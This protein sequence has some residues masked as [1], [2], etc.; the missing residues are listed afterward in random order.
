VKH[1]F[2]LPHLDVTT[3]PALAADAEAAGWDGVFVPDCLSIEV[4]GLVMP[5]SD[6]W[7]TLAAMA[8]ATRRVTLGPMVAAV[9]R[10]RPWKLAREVATLDILSGGRM[11]LPAGIGAADDDA[12][13]REVG[14]ELALKPRLALLDETLAI[15]DGLW[16]GEPFTFAGEHY[17]VGSMTQ[18]P[19]P[20]QRPRVPVWVVGVWPSGRSLR[21]SLRWDG[22]VVQV[23]EGVATPA[24]AREI[25]AM[26]GGRPFDIVVDAAASDAK[27]WEWEPA[28]VTWLLTSM[29]QND[30]PDSVRDRI[31]KG[32][33]A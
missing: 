26:A 10:R 28:G 24:I 18:R 17:R 7:V 30:G 27:A 32:P 16:S 22:I 6:P 23:R 19:V 12:G 31:S 13:F 1:G 33:E 4:P 2:V 25:G 21:R 11:V 3:A 14:E 8:V 29:W 9:T 15:V 5:A 20:A